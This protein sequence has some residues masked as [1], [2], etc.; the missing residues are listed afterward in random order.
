MAGLGIRMVVKRGGEF[1][2]D[3]DEA[4][5]GLGDECVGYDACYKGVSVCMGWWIGELTGT[6][7]CQTP[8][9]LFH[10]EAL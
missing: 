5:G 6:S 9:F 3:E 10:D 2:G 4:D 1:A 7:T 8:V